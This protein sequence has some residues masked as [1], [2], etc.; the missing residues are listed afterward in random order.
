[1][2]KILFSL[3]FLLCVTTI[4]FAQLANKI[5]AENVVEG[6]VFIDGDTIDGYFKRTGEAWVDDYS[7]EVYDSHGNLT[8]DSKKVVAPWQFQSK[9]HFIPKDLFE[10]H[11]KIKRKYFEKCSAKNCDGFRYDTL[12][13]ESV[14][15]ADMSAVGMN[16]IPKR[17]FL[18][19]VKDGNISLFLHFDTPPPVM[20]TKEVEK[21]YKECAIPHIVYR[22]GKRGKLKM[23]GALNIEKELADCEYVSEKYKKGEY[24]KAEAGS[25]FKKLL[26]NA[27]R[28][29]RAKFK[30]IQDYNANCGE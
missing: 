17:M 28:G 21:Y 29:D 12:I 22:K 9:M 23:V 19:R 3:M 8:S 16:M 6:T 24:G 14:K 15:Y 11:V 25:G 30:A 5:R 18:R 1:M 4:S 13:Y 7:R 26:N 20:K 27:L 2:K 10:K